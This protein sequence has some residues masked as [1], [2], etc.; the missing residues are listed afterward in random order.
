MDSIVFYYEDIVK[1]INN[2]TDTRN[3]LADALVELSKKI[4]VRLYNFYI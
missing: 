3:K 1:K 2:I 4:E